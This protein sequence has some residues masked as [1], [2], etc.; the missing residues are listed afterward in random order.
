MYLCS[1]CSIARTQTFQLHI[2]PNSMT[3]ARKHASESLSDISSTRTLLADLLCACATSLCLLGGQLLAGQHLHTCVHHSCLCADAAGVA[4]HKQRASSPKSTPNSMRLA[5]GP[6]CNTQ[7]T[8][9]V[10]HVFSCFVPMQ[11]TQHRTDREFPAPS[12]PP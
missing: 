9:R 4:L 5:Q 11:P 3:L 2:D 6:T 12:R 8:S 7:Q 10:L 1:F